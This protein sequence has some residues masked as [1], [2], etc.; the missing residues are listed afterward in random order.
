MNTGRV[1]LSS[2]NVKVQYPDGSVEPVSVTQLSASLQRGG[3]VIAASSLT[4]GED[5]EDDAF[6]A[7]LGREPT[8]ELA[9]QVAEECRRL[10]DG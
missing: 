2:V 5:D 10:L 1:P 6:A 4:G 7:V 9:A 3:K 8:P